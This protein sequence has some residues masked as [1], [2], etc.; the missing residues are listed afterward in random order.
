[1]E[2]HTSLPIESRKDVQ[3]STK[4]ALNQRAVHQ[5]LVADKDWQFNNKE[6]RRAFEGERAIWGLEKNDLYL[7]AMSCP[8][9]KKKEARNNTVAKNPNFTT[10]K[11]LGRFCYLF[12]ENGFVDVALIWPFAWAH[13]PPQVRPL[14]ALGPL[15]RPVRDLH[16]RRAGAEFQTCCWIV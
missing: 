12:E 13:K 6:F 3:F 8:T 15:P 2:C 10:G 1:M 4:L 7:V 9:K 11:G 5:L 16:R 14:A